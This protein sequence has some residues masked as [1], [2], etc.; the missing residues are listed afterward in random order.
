MG[1]RS[2]VGG[3][4]TVSSLSQESATCRVVSVDGVPVRVS[5]MGP[6]TEHDMDAL[7]EFADYLRGLPPTPAAG[8]PQC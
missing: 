5:S 7:R 1:A 3:G 4:V 6:L 8:Q 2:Y